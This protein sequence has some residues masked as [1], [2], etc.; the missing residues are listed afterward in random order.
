MQGDLKR[1]FR[2]GKFY[3]AE[4]RLALRKHQLA[5]YGDEGGNRAEVERWRGEVAALK[6]GCESHATPCANATRAGVYSMSVTNYDTTAEHTAEIKAGRRSQARDCAPKHAP[7]V[8]RERA[9]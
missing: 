4:T 1:F 2:L 6:R 3:Q 9:G 8:D 7:G 5:A